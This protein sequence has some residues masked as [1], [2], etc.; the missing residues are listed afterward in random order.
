MRY[1]VKVTARA[2]R[3][4]VTQA[5]DGTLQVAVTAPPERGRANEAVITA[6]AEYWNVP[7]RAVRIVQGAAS[8]RKVVAVDAV[9][10]T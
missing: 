4:R 8:R 5:A 2:K 10:A 3:A 7:R 6:L 1:T 9:P